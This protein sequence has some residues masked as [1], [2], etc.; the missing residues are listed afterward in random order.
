MKSS[1]LLLPALYG[2]LAWA[3]VQFPAQ[4]AATTGPE[5]IQEGWDDAATLQANE[6]VALFERARKC[7]DADP[8]QADLG[9]AIALLDVQPTTNENVTRSAA[10]LQKLI[11][12]DPNNAVGLEAR[13]FLARIAGTTIA[14]L[15]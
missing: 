2:I 4:A 9:T 14:S 10:L 11:D 15:C 12:A 7:Q 5:L 3:E 13:Y 6:G 1:R 8:R